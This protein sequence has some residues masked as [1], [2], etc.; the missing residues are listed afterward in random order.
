VSIS[1]H[2][3]DTARG[4]PAAGLGVTLSHRGADGTWSE[5]AKEV[6]DADGRIPDL[7]SGPVGAG[8]YRVEFATAS[9]FKAIGIVAFYPEVS[10][11]FR[12]TEA[13]A[14]HHV[15]LLLSPF[16]YSTYRGT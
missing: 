16:G 13:G 1:T 2:V 8:E 15:P 4:L 3:L 9:Y 7:S 6:T 12:V 14:R 10:V 5:I 11:V